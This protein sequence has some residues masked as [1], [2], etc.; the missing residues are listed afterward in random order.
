MDT[1]TIITNKDTETEEQG[2]IIAKNATLPL[3]ILLSGNLGSGK[4]TFVKGI[5]KG[6]GIKS[7]L[8]SPTFIIHRVYISPEEKK[9]NHIDL[10]RLDILRQVESLD[11][12]EMLRQNSITVIEW[13]EKFSDY[14]KKLG[15]KTNKIKIT[16]EYLD[17]NKRKLTINE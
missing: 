4:T 11:I 2:K 9:L 12:K 8:I 15:E 6:L 5:A 13:S 10:Y 7:R 17:V 3:L 16:F 1:K 14:F